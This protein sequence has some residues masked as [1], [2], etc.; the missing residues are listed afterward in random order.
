MKIEA[1][2]R[3]QAMRA[4]SLKEWQAEVKKQHPNAKFTRE[5]GS[6]KTYGDQGDWTAHTGN[7]MQADVVGTFTA[8]AC[9]IARRDGDFDEYD[10]KAS[11]ANPLNDGVAFD[12]I[13]DGDPEDKKPLV[14]EFTDNDGGILPFD[15][16][17]LLQDD[18][19]YR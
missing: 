7:D 8:T 17:L 4:L 1:K 11:V 13:V 15:E 6:G 3:L 2:Q 5:D 18:I 16:N 12:T 9:W 14:Q 10:V 19:Q